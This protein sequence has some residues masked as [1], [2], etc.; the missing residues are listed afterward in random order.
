[1][2]VI[3]RK[4][5]PPIEI[6][7]EP[8]RLTA[9]DLKCLFDT[10][11]W[12]S[13]HVFNTFVKLLRREV[14]DPSIVLLDSSYADAVQGLQL[15]LAMK[16]LRKARVTMGEVEDLVIPILCSFHWFVVS[17]SL[18][19][20]TMVV[21]DSGHKYGTYRSADALDMYLVGIP[22]TRPLGTD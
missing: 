12:I 1:M 10:S 22:S 20:K 17:V 6:V 13:N 9:K 14:N 19:F 5:L 15:E 8:A 4:P 7:I 3:N 18:R 11:T 21:Y 2:D 16:C